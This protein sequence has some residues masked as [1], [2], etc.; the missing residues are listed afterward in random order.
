[1]KISQLQ[2]GETCTLL[3]MPES[4][5]LSP[6]I[7]KGKEVRIV[8]PRTGGEALLSTG[9]V[10]QAVLAVD[11][12]TRR[13]MTTLRDTD[14]ARLCWVVARQDKKSIP[15]V[16][17]QVHRFRSRVEWTGKV[18]FG[19]DERVIERVEKIAERGMN[20]ER[21][22]QWLAEQL[23]LPPI[24]SEGCVRAVATG[25]PDVTGRFRL[26]GALAGVEVAPH[27]ETLRVESVVPLRG[28]GSG[29]RPPEFLIEADL[30]FVDA[31]LAGKMRHSVRAQIERIV[32]EADSYIA[33]WEKYQTIERENLIRR[34]RELGWIPYH[35]FEPLPTGLWR[36]VVTDTNALQRFRSQL[37]ASGQEEVEAAREV[38]P[39]LLEDTRRVSETERRRF[40]RAAVGTIEH[41]RMDRREI[42]L[43]P[44]DEES[45]I[46][47]PTKGMLFGAL[48]GDRK[49]LERRE[50]AIRR[51]KSADAR[52]PQLALI[53]EGENPFVRRTDRVQALTDA[54][55]KVFEHEPTPE[56]RQAIDIAVN[57]PDIVVIQG[58][59]GTGKTKV[60]TAIEA[61]LAEL[62]EERPEIAGRT[63]LTS[64]QHDAVDHAA[65]KS[66]V[67]GLPPVRF[68]GR[69]G[70]RSSEDQ[71]QRWAIQTREHVEGVLAQL[72]EE[73]PLA[74]YRNV[75]DRLA[76]YASGRMSIE[77]L[78]RLLDELV[79]LPAGYLSTELWERL[80][81]F[82][83]GP[84][85]ARVGAVEVERDL[86]RKAVRGLR[87]T[88]EAF[89]DDGPRKARQA[90][91]RLS[92]ILSD[93]ER[94]L[95][96]RA[97][98]GPLGGAF[99]DIEA[100]SLL[101]EA[102]LDRLDP[103]DVP[104]ERRRVD[105][106]LL[107]ALNATVSTLHDRMR[108]SAAGV[109]DALQEYTEAL[110][111]DPHGVRRL[112]EHYAA[113]YA[114]T[115]QQAV[116]HYVVVAKGGEHAEFG[117]ENVIVDEAARANPLDLIIP[118]SLAKRRII[119]VGDHRQLPH[120]L[121]SDVEEVLAGT[122]REQEQHALKESLFQ[123]LFDRLPQLIQSDEFVR[124]VTLRDQFRMHPVLG[125][126][127][128]DVFYE[129]HR[130][131]F[132]SPRPAGDFAHS[133]DGYLRAGGPIC[134]AWRNIP[135]RQGEERQGRSKSRPIEARW[136]AK[137]VRRLLV[138]VGADVSIG[139]IS[140]YRA[141]VDE[142]MEN[143]VL[144][145]IAE[146]DPDSDEIDILPEWRTI[147]RDNGSREERLRVGTVDA[148]QGKEFDVVFLSITRSNSWPAE[149]EDDRRRKYGHLMLENR[150]CV[151][152]SRQRRLLIAVGDKTMFE[153]EE[154][155]EAVN[156]LSRFLE[157]C[158]GKDGLV[159]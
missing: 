156:G 109:A 80:R 14:P 88:P 27:A 31:T 145:G 87:T 4:G 75:R 104:G 38:P 61:R 43:R 98:A 53:L 124:V 7:D 90:A 95:L 122:V 62:Q 101:R 70:D 111:E 23:F 134:A 8:F 112:L 49:R 69:R 57:T 141:Q 18:S 26:L 108:Q 33:L 107:D 35:A 1:M 50:Q 25:S 133:I 29:F 86:M 97:A 123:R 113:V 115:C 76:S 84:D 28:G 3:L 159:T 52:M 110:R 45:D 65:S 147:E 64:Y 138:D 56:Q 44:L 154:A 103:G 106:A 83:R 151:A 89:S 144:E 100:L 15:E 46:L 132:R 55:R 68:G 94:E 36:F 135:R 146:R 41:I 39:E 58:P 22:C 17:V 85:A 42:L 120:L 150:L 48:L 114:A 91:Q 82:R 137:E 74:I 96:S 139:V 119:L 152:M 81:Q 126:F 117:F 19:V 63:L 93:D 148:F 6:E 127:I 67:F 116:G 34:A 5:A 30:E 157:L 10:A 99:E 20:S 130:E 149:T 12:A 16:T 158:G 121:E 79:D 9:N 60:I 102:L 92:S 128:S 143:L 77:E 37:T 59:P 40:A 21:V 13:R 155:R 72:P 105:A 125:K 54:A 73:R 129:P 32:A 66:L 51:L 78:R 11:D 131:G 136:I 153:T 24:G 140:F 2:H 47:P 71:V 142:L 118:L